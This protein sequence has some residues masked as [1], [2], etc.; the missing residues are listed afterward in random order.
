MS[1]LMKQFVEKKLNG[2]KMGNIYLRKNK[3]IEFKLP[4]K[5]FNTRKLLGCPKTVDYDFP[6][7]FFIF[8]S[9]SYYN[10]ICII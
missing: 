10:I 1:V 4:I 8:K 2:K 6:K 9:R 3:Y 5:L 7:V